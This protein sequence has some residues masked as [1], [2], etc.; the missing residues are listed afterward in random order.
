MPVRG[1]DGLVGRVV[2]TGPNAARVL[3]LTDGDSIVPVRRTRDGLPAIVAGRGDGMVD[4]RS[5]NATNVKFA[6]GDLF[7]S[8][9]IGGIYEPGVPVARVLKAGQD[10]VEARTFADP[11]TIDFALVEGAFMTMQPRAQTPGP[12]PAP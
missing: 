12:P 1:P 11:D 6:A 10:S 9:G 4:V 5:V 8:S 7:V 3:L 2:E